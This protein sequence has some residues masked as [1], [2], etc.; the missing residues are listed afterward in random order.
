MDQI[1][2]QS[3]AVAVNAGESDGRTLVEDYGGLIERIAIAVPRKLFDPGNSVRTKLLAAQANLVKSLRPEMTLVVLTEPESE[4][5]VRQWLS[6]ISCPCRF[7]IAVTPENIVM[8]ADFAWI[9]DSVHVWKTGAGMQLGAPRSDGGRRGDHAFWI[10]AHEGVEVEPMDMHLAGGNQLVGNEFRIV[11]YNSFRA[12]QSPRFGGDNTLEDACKR[13]QAIDPRRVEVYGYCSTG[14]SSGSLSSFENVE[15]V[16]TS[17]VDGYL[18]DDQAGMP[19]S[20]SPGSHFRESAHDVYSQM[21]ET[22]CNPVAHQYG[23]HVDLFVSLTGKV[24]DGLPVILVAE[25]ESVGPSLTGELLSYFQDSKKNLDLSADRLAKRGFKVIR[26]PVPYAVDTVRNELKARSYNNVILENE[27][28]DSAA[29]P[30]V[31]MPGFGAEEQDM[32]VYDDGNKSIWERLGF[33]VILVPGWNDLVYAEGA[34]RCATSILS[35][36]AV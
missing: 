6:E 27:V 10:G 17:C 1:L 25:A 21:S 29:R 33:D 13:I 11:G 23:F 7:D 34:L 20:R 16:R 14:T 19:E 3:A 28:R 26:N 2:K 4:Q 15:E 32:Q 18:D 5:S 36:R 31:W 30:L 35:R 8:P 22:V 24:V 12:S 9:R